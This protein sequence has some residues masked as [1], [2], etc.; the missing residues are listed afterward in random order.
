MKHS[1]K[2]KKYITKKA[3][4]DRRKVGLIFLI[5]V[6]LF[7]VIAIL[8]FTYIAASGH[9]GNVNL[10]QRSD[11]KYS[12]R[13]VLRADRGTIYA[14]DGT[15]VAYNSK[16]YNLYVVLDKKHVGLNNKPLYVTNKKEVASVLSKYIPLSEGKIYKALEPKK[17]NTFQ[18]EFG[19]A[20]SNLS[21]NV[22]NAIQ[23]HHLSGVYFTTSLTRSYPNGVFA[24]NVIGLAQ[25]KSNGP[26]S[27]LEG[28]MGLEKKYNSVLHG[29]DGYRVRKTDPEG[30]DLPDT[31]GVTKRPTEGNNLYTTLN[32]NYQQYLE[33]LMTDTAKKYKPENMQAIVTDPKTGDIIAMT[34]SPTFNPSTQEGLNDSWRDLNVQDQ[35]EPGSVM[36]VM[37]LAAAIQ[38]GHYNPKQYYRSGSVT[39]GDRT[40]KDWNLTGWGT[41]PISQAFPR[42]SNVGMVYLEKNMG[43]K[44][45]MKYMKRFH[46]GEK[47]GINLPGEVPGMIN[48]KHSSDQAITA[49]GQSVDVN[50]MQMVQAI[51]SIGNGGTMMKPRIVSKIQDP[52]T[53]KAK[54]IKPQE[55]GKPVSAKT[56]KKVISAM[57][58]VVNDKYGT[59]T[60]YKIPHQDVAV[61]TGTAQI[62]D[63]K[64]NGYLTGDSN[65]I[66][67][68]AGLAP[69]KDPK[70]LVYITMKQPHN[71]TEA[72]EK[73]LSEVFNPMMQRL[74]GAGNI[75]DIKSS[76]K[77]IN[78]P[79]ETTK[80]LNSV[81]K[82]LKDRNLQTGIAGT[83]NTVVQ[84]L[85]TA[86]TQILPGQ[87]VILLTNGAMT[88][89]DVKGWSKNDLL[90]LSEITGKKFE[91][92][93][94]G[95]ADSQNVKP[96][97]VLN[98]VDKV[99]IK[100]K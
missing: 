47:T 19:P 15:K 36:K 88:M 98:K 18:V 53:G 45:W 41:I 56:S 58:E 42:S 57:R 61:K 31:K 74:L 46:L 87:R 71:M 44:T 100:L 92:E 72:P 73:I 2:N 7:F 30:Y 3:R 89:P 43:A 60:V 16:S 93:G 39:V 12:N 24:S 94:Q 40:I 33:Q 79:E 50:S 99:T 27:T 66:F 38:S 5:V 67:S 10:T 49:F 25:N 91:F 11:Q 32:P 59:G 29:K 78:M 82:D 21:L 4:T 63:P 81:K 85:P 6:A 17:K 80:S 9:V 83:G 96:G 37:T 22:K 77:S 1:D 28:T 23:S 90:K 95:Y 97:Q 76:N 64:G 55:V 68:V 20:G 69:A 65:Y 34:Q 54:T 52:N 84:Q 35:Y 75:E 8:R 26:N 62:A 70:Y 86:D 13:K 48:F 51:G 14:Q